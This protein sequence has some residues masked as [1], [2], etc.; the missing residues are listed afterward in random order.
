MTNKELIKQAVEMIEK[1]IISTSALASGGKLN[2]DQANRMI[3]FV[4]DETQLKGMVRLVRMRA[5]QFDIDKIGVGKRVARAKSEGVDPGVRRG[6]QTSKVSLNKKAIMVPFELTTEFLED[7]IETG[8]TLEDHVASM[9][10]N[11]FANDLENMY[12]A[13]DQNGPAV[14]EED[15][16]DGGA[17]DEVVDD[18]LALMD[19]W[20][21]LSGTGHILDADSAG[22]SS[23]IFSRAKK[24]LPTKFRR[25]LN[26]MRFF[27]P[28]DTEETYRNVLA[29]RGTALGDNAIQNEIGV[30]AMGVQLQALALMEPNPLKVAHV[31]LT[32]TTPAQLGGDK[33]ITDAIAHLQTLS[34]TPTAPIAD[35]GDIEFDLA[36]G[37]VARS[38]GSSLPTP[39]NVKVTYRAQTEMLLCEGR[40]LILGIGRDITIKRDEDIFKDVRQWAMTVR[41]AVEI[42]ETDA[43]VLVKNIAIE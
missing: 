37:T 27:L 15:I 36:A 33:N 32:G 17:T 1:G 25:R 13:G 28:M 18:L 8:S 16:I 24:Q 3:D 20:V 12:I 7:A 4:F 39:V 22:I 31:T 5:E 43:V 14:P 40:N 2:A 41:V 38:G 6:V 42:E 26:M 29:S 21:K 23:N 9:M 10:G 11:A 19:G 30:K 34:T 35:P